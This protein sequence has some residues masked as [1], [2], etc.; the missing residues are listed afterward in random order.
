MDALPIPILKIRGLPVLLDYDLARLYAI[1]VKALNQAVKRNPD[2]FPD[3]FAF[4]LTRDE[5]TNLRSQIVTSGLQ[6][7]ETESPNWSQIVTCSPES[8]EAERKSSRMTPENTA[9]SVTSPRPS[10]NTEHSWPRMSSAAPR[11]SV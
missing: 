9:A 10:P 3:D 11:P 1:P 6:V 4:Q 8:P 5:W 2:R 7:V